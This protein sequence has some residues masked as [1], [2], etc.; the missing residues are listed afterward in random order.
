MFHAT[1]YAKVCF[2]RSV[3]KMHYYFEKKDKIESY[4]LSGMKQDFNMAECAEKYLEIY[5]EM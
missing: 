1:V 3:G 5:D 4:I 2:I